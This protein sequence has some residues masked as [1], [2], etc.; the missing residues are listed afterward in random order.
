M[1]RLRRFDEQALALFI[2]LN[3]I[4]II[5]VFE[6]RHEIRDWMSRR[7]AHRRPSIAD[8][9]FY[10]ELSKTFGT[11]ISEDQL[12]SSAAPSPT[13]DEER[14]RKNA[15]SQ[16]FASP[17]NP[18]S[19]DPLSQPQTCKAN[20]KYQAGS[21][22]SCRDIELRVC[23]PESKSAHEFNFGLLFTDAAHTI[24]DTNADITLLIQRFNSIDF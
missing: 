5:H 13:M 15:V 2:K 19:S 8:L 1:R 14:S 4:N 16:V 24:V 3:N 12:S 23:D 22:R 7:M 17:D 21:N 11:E 10:V 6:R 9:Y 20:S 18:E